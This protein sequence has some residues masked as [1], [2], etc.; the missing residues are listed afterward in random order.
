MT[1]FLLKQFLSAISMNFSTIVDG[2][3]SFIQVI[4]FLSITLSSMLMN[5][6][7]MNLLNEFQK[8]SLNCTG[9]LYCISE[10]ICFQNLPASNVYK[11]VITFLQSISLSLSFVWRI[12]FNKERKCFKTK[13]TVW[14]AFGAYFQADN[15]S[16]FY[17]LKF[18]PLLPW[19][20]TQQL[21]NQTAHEQ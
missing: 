10:C 15:N 16:F 12:Q 4:R 2:F 8:Y 21:T 18:K 1:T 3:L 19:K 11:C 9:D 14:T 17:L 5:S 20:Y 13:V 7:C 6:W